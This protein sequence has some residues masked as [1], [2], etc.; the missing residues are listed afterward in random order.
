MCQWAHFCWPA[1][2]VK[3]ETGK[4]N[5]TNFLGRSIPCLLY[6][7]LIHIKSVSFIHLALS[8][9][10]I[11]PYTG[12]TEVLEG[13]TKDIKCVTEGSPKPTVDWY[14]NGK[15]MN[16]TNCH[17]NPQSC[18]KVDYEVYEEGDGS[19][20]LHTIYTVQ[21]LKIRSALYPRD[22]GDFKCV[23]SNGVSPDAELI[24]SL[25]VQGT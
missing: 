24:V 3:T 20:G 16:V 13:S 17:S 2:N 14:R 18:D 6:W 8:A 4:R 23:A 5:E 19:S 22:V 21:V 15:K 11:L 7:L 12:Q 10:S 1:I 9:P 25:D